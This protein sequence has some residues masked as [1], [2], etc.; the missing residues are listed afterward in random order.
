[1]DVAGSGD[2][3]EFVSVHHLVDDEK[4]SFQRRFKWPEL[5][6]GGGPTCDQGEGLHSLLSFAV[7]ELRKNVRPYT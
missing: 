7:F 1:M 2:R 4:I 6:K 5:R 3:T